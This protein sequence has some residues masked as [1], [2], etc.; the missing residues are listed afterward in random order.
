MNAANTDSNQQTDNSRSPVEFI[1]LDQLIRYRIKNYF[2]ESDL[3]ISAEPDM[4]EFQHW[5]RDLGNFIIRQQLSKES[6][7]LLLIGLTPYLYPDLFDE[8]IKSELPSNIDDFPKIGGARGKNCRFFLPTGETAIFL[9]AADNYEKRSEVEDLFGAE[10]LFWEKKILWL[11]DMQHFEPPMHGRIIMSQDYV[12]F[13]TSGIHKSPQFSI[14][15]PAKK[16]ASG[17]QP[18]PAPVVTMQAAQG[19]QAPPSPWEQLVISEDLKSQIDEIRTWLRYNEE[20]L[21]TYD[22]H[23]NFRKGFRTLFYGP[24]GTGKTFTAKLLGDELARDVYKIDLSLV[25]SKYIGETEKNLEM[26]FARA[27]D[28]GWILFFDE[29][30]ALFGKRTNVR[31][32][33]DKYANQETSYLLQ[34]IEDYNGLIILATNMKNNIDDAF[35]RRF[36]S[37]LKFPLPDIDERKLI[38]TKLF[39]PNVRF[40]VS[41]DT[42]KPEPVDIPEKVKGTELSG[43]NI[44]NIVHYACLKA[45]ERKSSLAANAYCPEP[46]GLTVYLEDVINGIRR[47]LIKE[48]RPFSM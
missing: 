8:A 11:E 25:V 33:H 9:I 39:P 16:I 46:P 5:Q 27:E 20:L 22:S 18:K 12:D 14:S 45:L 28:K 36:N 10:Y 4:P 29:A 7:L 42:D 17:S 24:P 38:W 47:E 26:L 44:N 13:L 32:A 30:D 1:Y 34:R 40:V 21:E 41:A 23:H 43:G 37:I 3:S 15:F 2:S 19:A 48:G 35:I 31:D 6:A